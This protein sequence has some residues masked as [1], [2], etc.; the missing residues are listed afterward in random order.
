MKA[1]FRPYL[2]AKGKK[3]VLEEGQSFNVT[4]RTAHTFSNPLDRD[5]KFRTTYKPALNIDYLLV[6]GFDSLNRQ[7]DPNKPSFQMLVDFAIILKQIQGQYKIAGAAGIIFTI[8]AAIARLYIKP[9]VR[10]LKE[11]NASL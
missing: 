7:T 8:F 4:A 3:I 1:I 9:K 5:T 11:H 2:S 6:Q 10:T